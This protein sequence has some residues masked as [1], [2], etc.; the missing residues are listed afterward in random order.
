M[1]KKNDAVEKGFRNFGHVKVD[2]ARNL[3]PVELS[4]YKYVMFVNPDESVKAI[5]GKL[6]K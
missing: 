1:D 2:E 4:T 3:N 5:A 6:N